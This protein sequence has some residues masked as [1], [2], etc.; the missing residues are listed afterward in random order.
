MHTYIHIYTHIIYIHIY[1]YIYTFIYFCIKDVINTNY[2]NID[3]PFL[4]NKKDSQG[5][6]S[7]I[8]S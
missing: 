8:R 4:L 3:D 6:I 2:I 5:V 7:N 1:M